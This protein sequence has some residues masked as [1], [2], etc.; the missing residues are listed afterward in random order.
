MESKKRHVFNADIWIDA[1]PTA[2][3]LGDGYDHCLTLN[4]MKAIS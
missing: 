2:I 3:E 4:D 1:I